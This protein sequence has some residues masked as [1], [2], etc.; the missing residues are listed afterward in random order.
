MGDLLGFL[1]SGIGII[2][3]F[4]ILLLIAANPA[5]LGAK[6]KSAPGMGTVLSTVGPES[7]IA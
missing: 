3:I 5:R 2:I 4:V 1:G 7:P 6:R